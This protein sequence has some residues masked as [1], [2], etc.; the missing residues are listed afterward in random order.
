MPSISARHLPAIRPVTSFGCEQNMNRK[1]SQH[2][3]DVNPDDPSKDSFYLN[4]DSCITS[5][6]ISNYNDA[7]E[8]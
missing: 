2:I 6:F 8:G 5:C 4:S 3:G 7:Q 1:A